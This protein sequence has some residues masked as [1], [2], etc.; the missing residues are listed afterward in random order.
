[1]DSTA[2]ESI[3]PVVRACSFCTSC[4]VRLDGRL[5][6]GVELPDGA[7]VQRVHVGF[8]GVLVHVDQHAGPVR[9]G[10]HGARAVPKLI[11]VAAV[12]G[13]DQRGQRD[14]G[15]RDHPEDRRADPVAGEDSAVAV[16]TFRRWLVVGHAREGTWLGKTAIAP[17]TLDPASAT[18]ATAAR[19]PMLPINPQPPTAICCWPKPSISLTQREQ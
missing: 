14:G 4:A 16:V 9:G 18:I 15:D 19:L 8:D 13:P 17:R 5:E 10:L 2:T 3:W 1:M 12:L 6:V 11:V 7:L